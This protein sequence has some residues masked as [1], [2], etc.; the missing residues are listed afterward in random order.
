MTRMPPLSRLR[1]GM[2]T[3]EAA[4]LDLC[5]RVD[6]QDRRLE[7]QAKQIHMQQLRIELLEQT[8]RTLRR[9]RVPT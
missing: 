5:D 2:T 9:T 1:P 4:L 7:A 6:E 8:N 3:V